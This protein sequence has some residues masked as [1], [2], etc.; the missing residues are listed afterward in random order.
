M[1]LIRGIVRETS[2]YISSNELENKKL[3]TDWN[4]FVNL[5]TS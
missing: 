3:A 4:E 2:S 5:V 1:S